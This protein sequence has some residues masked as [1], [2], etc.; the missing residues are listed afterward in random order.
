MQH[1]VGGRILTD[2]EMESMIRSQPPD[3]D[4]DDQAMK[5]IKD[6]AKDMFETITRTAQSNTE[7]RGAETID[8]ADVRFVNRYFIPLPKQREM[9]ALEMERRRQIMAQQAQQAQ[10]SQKSQR[11]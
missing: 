1:N 3:G 9:E 2:S 6:L 8:L 4:L 11:R 7:L 5:A 10:Q